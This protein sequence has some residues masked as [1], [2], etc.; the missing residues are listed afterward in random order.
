MKKLFV[1][2]AASMLAASLSACGGALV[3]LD[4]PKS[5]EL[6]AQYDFYSDSMNDIRASMGITPEQ[7]DEVFIALTASGLDGKVTKIAEQKNPDSPYFQVWQGG[8][9][10]E[11][12]LQD[13]AVEKIMQGKDTLYP[14]FHKH[15]V[16]TDYDL[17]VEDVKNGTGDSV[18]GQRAYISITK[19]ALKEITEENYKEFAE[20]VV[21]DSGYNWVS[22][23][24]DDG[25]GICFAGS[26]YS[27][28]TYGELDKEGAIVEGSGA[29]ALESDGAYSYTSYEIY[30]EI[31]ETVLS[32]IPSEYQNS[33][34]FDVYADS[35]SESERT[36]TIQIDFGTDDIEAIHASEKEI[37]D[38]CFDTL[39]SKYSV[40]SVL[41]IA[42]NGGA[43][44][45]MTRFP[46]DS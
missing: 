22:I 18:I 38:S 7:A 42:V 43:S 46:L 11:V 39:N 10:Y 32:F 20:T 41:F 29:I 30:G 33:E 37:F 35:Y 21:K 14:E 24:C 31:E 26:N 27:V 23:V 15:N 12:Y 28:G 4:T 5:E 34:W 3:D 19:S 17:I 13:G 25:T 36:V 9:S 45:D 8:T 16:L 1:L 2:L 6:S 40:Q 44:V